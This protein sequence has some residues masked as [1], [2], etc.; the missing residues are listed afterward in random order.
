MIRWFAAHPTA[1]N[2]LMLA[3]LLTSI[4]TVAGLTPLLLETSTQAQL[5]M[6]IVASLAFGLTTATAL[7][8]ATVPVVARIL[9]DFGHRPARV[10]GSGQGR[11]L[12]AP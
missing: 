12:L 4:A 10:E 7:S 2:L 11:G 5:L 6:P 9:D 8:L 3:I 1:A